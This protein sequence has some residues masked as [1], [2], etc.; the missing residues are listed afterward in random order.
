[1]ALRQRGW[2]PQ[3]LDLIRFLSIPFL[4]MATLCNRAGHIY[5]HPVVSSSFFISF[6][7]GLIS[8]VGDW[9]STILPHMV[10]LSVNYLECRSEK[11]CARLAENT[12]RKTSPK[13]RHLGTIAQFC[14]AISSQLR[15]ISTTGK[16]LG[17]QRYILHT[18]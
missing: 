9:M 5:F 17:K 14:R 7:P 6:F 13:I 10:C 12:A 16:K 11:C 1:M 15:H 4:F 8:A 18:S 2:S 3:T